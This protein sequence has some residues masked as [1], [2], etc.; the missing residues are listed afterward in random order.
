MRSSGGCV[1]IGSS[2]KMNGSITPEEEDE[3]LPKPEALR[4]ENGETSFN[5]TSGS[6]VIFDIF[7]SMVLWAK[8][9]GT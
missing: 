6:Q 2:D 9:L 5:F 1:H 4:S 8:T 3:V 7:L